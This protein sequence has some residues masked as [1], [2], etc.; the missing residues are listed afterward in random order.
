MSVA[1]AAVPDVA[2]EMGP[3][4]T[5]RLIGA[6]VALGVIA[7]LVGAFMLLTRSPNQSGSGV[8]VGSARGTDNNSAS[9]TSLVHKIGNLSL[10]LSKQQVERS[11]GS[12]TKVVGNCWQYTVNERTYRISGGKKKFDGGTWNAERLCFGWPGGGELTSKQAEVD[13]KWQ[14]PG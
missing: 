12:P 7:A 8:S 9:D 6:G 4:N 11:L 1:A 2:V 13:G 5:R 10:G 3:R 14:S